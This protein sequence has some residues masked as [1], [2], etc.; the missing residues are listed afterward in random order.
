MEGA[1]VSIMIVSI[2]GDEIESQ[3]KPKYG[4]GVDLLPYEGT[5]IP[6][7]LGAMKFIGKMSEKGEECG[8]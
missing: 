6:E 2:W 5:P 7:K 3:N 8:L 4:K 1:C